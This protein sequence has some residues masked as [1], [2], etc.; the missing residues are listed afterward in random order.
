MNITETKI[1]EKFIIYYYERSLD[2]IKIL[3]IFEPSK[4]KKMCLLRNFIVDHVSDI[5]CVIAKIGSNKYIIH[6]GK[7]RLSKTCEDLESAVKISTADTF[8]GCGTQS[9]GVI[10]PIL[11]PDSYKAKILAQKIG[12]MEFGYTVILKLMGLLDYFAGI[13]L[14]YQNFTIDDES[15]GL[16]FT[17]NKKKYHTDSLKYEQL[18]YII[19]PNPGP[20]DPENLENNSDLVRNDELILTVSKMIQEACY[21][22]NYTEFTLKDVYNTLLSENNRF[23]ET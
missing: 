17:M 23:L 11:H 20:F 2:K 10:N 21:S 19:T 14:Y 12:N 4:L 13:N 5:L 7:L 1:T 9:V 3:D 15:A 6:S 22:Y 18:I 8:G 16:T